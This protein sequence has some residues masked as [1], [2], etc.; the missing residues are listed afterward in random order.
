M[1]SQILK[2]CAGKGY[3][4]PFRQENQSQ[5]KSDSSLRTSTNADE[6][7]SS[8]YKSNV[9]ISDSDGSKAQQFTKQTEKPN[10]KSKFKQY[11]A[12]TNQKDG[13]NKLVI[14]VKTNTGRES[15][16]VI[17]NPNRIERK[18]KRV[19]GRNQDE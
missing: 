14:S 10:G 17:T 5:V 6:K 2:H 16:R 3:N 4:S 15:E 13:D 1:R 8:E 9:N 18:M 19:L 12:F 11:N 7:Y